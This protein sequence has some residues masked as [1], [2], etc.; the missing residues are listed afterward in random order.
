MKREIKIWTI[1]EQYRLGS[2]IN[3]KVLAFAFSLSAEIERNLIA[4]RTREA[5]MRKKDEGLKL[6]RPEGTKNKELKLLKYKDKIQNLL[7]KNTTKAEISK[8]LK[9]SRPTLNLFLKRHF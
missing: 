3:C 8:V 6:G 9:V 7:E 1:K 4:S 5:L 2:D